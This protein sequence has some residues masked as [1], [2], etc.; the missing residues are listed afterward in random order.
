MHLPP[1]SVPLLPQLLLWWDGLVFSE[2]G[3]VLKAV[4]KEELTIPL[5]PLAR[6]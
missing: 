4:K 6:R 2:P 5:F 1:L 3:V